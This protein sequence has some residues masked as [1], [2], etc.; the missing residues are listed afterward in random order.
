VKRDR[1]TFDLTITDA[2]GDGDGDAFLRLRA[3]LKRMLRGYCFRCVS[4]VKVRR[5]PD[6]S[7]LTDNNPAAG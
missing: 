5:E 2:G 6:D 3:L 4:V 1:L 7:D